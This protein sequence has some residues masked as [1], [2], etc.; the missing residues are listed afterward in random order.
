MIFK[1]IAYETDTTINQ[2]VLI[3]TY[4]IQFFINEYNNLIMSELAKKFIYYT[5][6][7]MNEF[8]QH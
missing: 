6:I 5:Q 3:F 1:F 2:L 4:Y 8:N 7:L